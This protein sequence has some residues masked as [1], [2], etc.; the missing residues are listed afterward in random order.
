MLLTA[1]IGVSFVVARAIEHLRFKADAYYYDLD[2]VPAADGFG[3]LVAAIYGLCLTLLVL[4]IHSGDLWSSPGKTLALLFAT[5][6]LFNWGLELIAALVVNGRLQTPI[7]PG[8]VDR[9]GYILGIWYRNFA[10]EVGYVASIPVLLWVIRKSKRQG[11]TWRLAWLGFLLFAFLIVGYVHFGVRD[12]VHPPLSHWYFELAIGIPIVLLIVAT[13]NA[14]IR[15][16][17]VDWWTA[18]TVTPIAFVWCLGMA[19]KLLA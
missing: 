8:A 11:F 14:F 12:Y 6:C 5:M 3:M 16:R 10:A 17:P 7:D 18:L 2:A 9:R 4:A 15:R 19:M 1:G 13:A